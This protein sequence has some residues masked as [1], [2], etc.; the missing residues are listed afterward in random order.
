MLLGGFRKRHA[1]ALKLA[2]ALLRHFN[3]VRGELAAFYD[4]RKTDF[5]SQFLKNMRTFIEL[6]RVVEREC[7]KLMHF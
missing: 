5:E 4:G 7:A 3:D 1:E 6:E 2:D